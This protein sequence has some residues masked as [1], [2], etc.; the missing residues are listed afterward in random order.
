M[1]E[2]NHAIEHDYLESIVA[3]TDQIKPSIP[4]VVATWANES[5]KNIKAIEDLDRVLQV[6]ALDDP[7]SFNHGNTKPRNDYR[8]FLSTLEGLKS[9]PNDCT[10]V[11]K[12]RTDQILNIPLL[13]EEFEKSCALESVK[14][15]TA[16]FRIDNPFWLADHYFGG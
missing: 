10:H 8:Q 1:R 16:L 11:V 3:V 4:V 13:L 9:L 5:E 14:F 12:L 7:K 15:F 6:L 2:P